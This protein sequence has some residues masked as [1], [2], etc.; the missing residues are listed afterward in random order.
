[1][2]NART[3]FSP[4]SLDTLPMVNSHLAKLGLGALP[5]DG[6]TSYM[7]RN[8]NWAGTTDTGVGVFVKQLWGTAE[9]CAPRIR[10]MQGFDD[11]MA[12]AA[13][14]AP[15]TIAALPEHHLVISELITKARTAA[16]L[17]R[18]D[19]FTLD[20]ARQAGT[21]VGRLHRC[22]DYGELDTSTPSLPDVALCDIMRVE[23]YLSLTAAELAFH[24]LAQSDLVL[25]EALVALRTWEAYAPRVPAHCDLRLDQFLIDGDQLVL[26][27]GEEFRLADPA[28]DVGSYVGE[29]LFQAV[30]GLVDVERQ[31]SLAD[32]P[33]SHEE[34]IRMGSARLTERRPKV[35]TFWAAYQEARPDADEKLAVR[36][37]AFAGWH[38]LNRVLANAEHRAR[39]TAPLRAA[40]GI[41]RQAL[42]GPERFVTAL[43]LGGRP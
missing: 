43:G 2:G 5:P 22:A 8:T 4:A 12:N 35:E 13:L 10:R 24:R 41:G 37:T 6:I 16:E 34:V 38:V 3:G 14:P 31:Q 15:R 1:M 27:D 26:T 7:G 20:M 39:L 21:I 25:R 42:Q 32:E 11:V 40:M 18:D 30:T 36:A 23:F 17:A 9:E 28:R 33:L 29:W 19:E